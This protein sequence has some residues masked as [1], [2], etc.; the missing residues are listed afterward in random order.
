MS[1]H[2]HPLVV[3]LGVLAAMLAGCNP[4]QP[5]YLFEDGDLS[6]YIDQATDIDYPDVELESLA[7]VDGSIRPFSLDNTEPKEIWALSLEEAVQAALANSKVMKSIGGQIQGMPDFLL[8]ASEIVPTIYDPAITESNPRLGIEAALSAFDA[9]FSSSIFW[10]KNDT[11]RN[12]VGFGAIFPPILNQELG[13]FQAQLSKFAADGGT[14]SIR[15]NVAYEWND[16]SIRRYPSDWNVNVEAEF[17]QPLLQG[18]GVQF[19]RIAGPGAIPGFNNGVMIARIR[20][21]ITLADFEAGV[22][23]LVSDV[24]IAYWE[25]YYSYRFLDA[26]KAG[27]DSGL[28]TWRETSAKQKVGH[29]EGDRHDE[30]RA[31]QQ[32]FLF[33]NAMERAQSDLFAAESKLRY[34][35]G[36]AATDGRL[37][38]PGDE[39]SIAKVAFDWH[40]T[41]AEGLA[42][43][44]ELRKQHWVVKQRQLELI[45]AKNYLLPR[46]DAVG[47][48][49]WLG[50]GDDLI[51]PSGGSGNPV[52]LNSNAYQSMTSGQFQEWHF[53]VDLS[54]PLGFRK[55]MAG[56]RHAQ[57]NLARERARL[58][59]QELEL[60]HQ[61]AFVIRD[62][63]A[64]RVLAGTNFNRLAAAK[65]EADTAE[66]LV[67]AGEGGDPQSGGKQWTLDALLDAQRRLAEAE[68]DFYRSVVDYN[69][70]IAQVHYIKG[71]LLEYNGVH[72]TEGP[73]AGKAY[74]DAHRRARKRDAS[75]YLNYGFTR[76]NV[77]SR[78]PYAQHAGRGLPE[79]TFVPTEL[80]PELTPAMPTM[81]SA[82][83]PEPAGDSGSVDFGS[84]DS[85]EPS[86]LSGSTVRKASFEEPT[87]TTPN[88]ATDNT[89]IRTDS[90]PSP[91]KWTRS[92][93]ANT[94]N[95]LLANPSAAKAS[96]PASGW[97]RVQR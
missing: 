59:E 43:S 37:I 21:D 26:M 88:N 10:E 90:D 5:F 79:E 70:A 89:P 36:L 69:K 66:I 64:A 31:R 97:K 55:E 62:L 80:T 60:S 35:M 45:A 68:A 2:F 51:Q 92:T 41:L 78:G 54:F 46:I 75:L 87:A 24:E 11:P 40:E 74:F 93:R 67:K 81:P 50:L 72:L 1:C 22:R 42:R 27:R 17:R 34:M 13:N 16:T 95:E 61:L 65:A 47:R 57:L 71:S 4:Q 18:A 73:W 32:Y 39:P 52:A 84:L 6:H 9:Q 3:I 96:R 53:G 82:P 63:E 91:K 83:Q 85:L 14:W 38:R 86:S 48:Y 20:T 23:D 30:A 25:L 49:R 58:Q 7:E 15:H 76:P 29:E 8:R 19:N 12:F 56:V 44:V 94:R 33:R 28:Q 77:I